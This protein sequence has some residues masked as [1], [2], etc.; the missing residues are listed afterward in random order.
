MPDDAAPLCRDAPEIRDAKASGTAIMRTVMDE[1]L[2]RASSD[3]R[4]RAAVLVQ[5][6]PARVGHCVSGTLRE[7]AEIERYAVEAADMLRASVEELGC[8]RQALAL[9]LA[10]A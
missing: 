10:R 3:I 1:A 8:R 6:I 9:A 2:P 5:T 4:D 7:P